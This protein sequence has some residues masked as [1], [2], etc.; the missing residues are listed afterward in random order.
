MDMLIWAI[1]ASLGAI[2]VIA[3]VASVVVTTALV[4]AWMFS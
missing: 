1:G 2:A 4:L 3:A